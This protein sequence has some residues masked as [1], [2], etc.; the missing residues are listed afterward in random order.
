MSFLVSTSSKKFFV[1]QILLTRFLF[2]PNAPANKGLSW[3][4]GTL[5][6]LSSNRNSSARTCLLLLKF[7]TRVF[8][9]SNLISSPGTTTSK[10]PPITGNS[11]RSPGISAQGFLGI[12]NFVFQSHGRWKSVQAKDTWM[13][14]LIKGFQFPSLSGSRSFHSLF[15]PILCLS[16]YF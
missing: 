9:Y 3:I 7:L 14:T 12:F 10:F 6:L 11:L 2:R 16:T 15:R 4:L 1:L 13:M 5:T 8:V